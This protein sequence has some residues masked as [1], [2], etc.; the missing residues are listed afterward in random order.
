[1]EELESATNKEWTNQEVGDRE[2]VQKGSG[3]NFNFMKVRKEIKVY[4]F[5][6]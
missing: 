2:V 1:V 4:R 6:M 5:T 3:A